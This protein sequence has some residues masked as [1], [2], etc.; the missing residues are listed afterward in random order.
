MSCLLIFMRLYAGPDHS[1][2]VPLRN[3]NM[4]LGPFQL[5]GRVINSLSLYVSCVV[6]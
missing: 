6:H 5:V 3:V 2:P 1:M 4:V